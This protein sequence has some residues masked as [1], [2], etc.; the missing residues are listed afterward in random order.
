MPQIHSTAIVDTKANLAND[1]T[2][3]PYAIIERDVEIGEGSIVGPHACIYNG[4]R[5]GKNVKIY[6]AAAVS[7]IPQDLKYAGE[8]AFFYIADNTVIREYVTLHKGTLDTGF[9]K[10]GSNCLIMAYVHIAHDCVVGDN[11]ILA[12]SVQIAGHVTIGNWTII[13]GAAVVHQFGKTGEHCMIQGAAKVS[14]DVP[15]YVLTGSD[16]LKY[17]GLNSIGLRRRGFSN[18]DI[19]IIKD[20]YKV[21]FNSGLNKSDAIKKLE[22]DFDNKYVTIIIDFLN[23]SNRS[24]I[25]K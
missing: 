16:P 3:G 4:A 10:V 23:S 19:S 12:N 18:E 2:V 7:N 1:V 22:D 11:V 6:Q 24:L 13:G 20:A 15:P 5:I 25:K 8:E 9:S 21:V 17:H 14:S